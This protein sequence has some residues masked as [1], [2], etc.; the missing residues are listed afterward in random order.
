[1]R[2]VGKRAQTSMVKLILRFARELVQE[3]ITHI[4]NH[5]DGGDLIPTLDA[6]PRILQHGEPFFRDR[7]LPSVPQPLEVAHN[8]LQVIL[9]KNLVVGQEL[10][11][12]VLVPISKVGTDLPVQLLSCSGVKAGNRTE[13]DS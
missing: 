13:V 11:Q 7:R 4:I 12:V 2:E 9:L 3:I 1:M 5:E 8:R 10:T 6:P